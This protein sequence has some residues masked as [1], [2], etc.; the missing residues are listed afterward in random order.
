MHRSAVTIACVLLA[1]LVAAPQA[2]A[3]RG[4]DARGKAR[5]A[6]RLIKAAD[7]FDVRATAMRARAVELRRD[8]TELRRQA[9]DLAGDPASTEARTA[10]A[11]PCEE[12]TVDP[13]LEDEPERA[14]TG[15]HHPVEED[16]GDG[17]DEGA[18]EE[19][20]ASVATPCS[21]LRDAERLETK[22]A[23]LDVAATRMSGHAT[24]LRTKASALLGPAGEG[25][26]KRLLA[27]AAKLR[28][29]AVALRAKADARRESS[30]EG[31]Q[32][33]DE[34]IEVVEQLELQAA[35]RDL[36]ADRLEARAAKL[37]A[38]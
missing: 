5:S 11:D 12:P 18:F 9:E 1:L 2:V 25:E 23:A 16:E 15:D 3:K 22:A 28:A 38:S 10:D 32:V 14:R 31:D 19:D 20:E 33:D 24:R 7:R 13:I 6:E 34:A 21:L 8:A 37:T 26:A 36:A 17:S 30:F 35:G 4:S 29:K 27:K